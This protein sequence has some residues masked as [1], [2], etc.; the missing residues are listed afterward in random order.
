MITRREAKKRTDEYL[1]VFQVVEDAIIEAADNGETS[2]SVYLE[3]YTPRLE[4]VLVASKFDIEINEGFG[5][6]LLRV[7]WN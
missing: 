1:N 6:T 3:E 5:S 2:A 4:Q 7:S